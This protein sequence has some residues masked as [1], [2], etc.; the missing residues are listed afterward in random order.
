RVGDVVARR[1]VTVVAPDAP[2]RDCIVALTRGQIPLALV[3][4]GDRLLGV[5]SANELD[6]VLQTPERL[7]QSVASVMNSSPPVI[8]PEA[9]VGEAERRMENDGVDAMLVVDAAGKVHGVFVR[10]KRH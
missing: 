10:Q 3:Y 7:A 5:I 2:L 1:S 9:L 8:S 4:D 6:D